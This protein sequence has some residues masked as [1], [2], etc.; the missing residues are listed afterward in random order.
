M[1]VL[2]ELR[3]GVEGVWESVSEGWRHLRGSAASALTRFK[4]GGKSSVPARVEDDASLPSPGWALLAGDIF[5]DSKKV[6]IRLEVPGME[7]E[8]FDIEVREDVVI[9]RG[10]KRLEQQVSEG[11]YRVMQCAYGTF[12]RTIP[13][14]GPVIAD[15]AKATY[16]NG[17]LKITLPKAKSARAR[18][19]DIRVG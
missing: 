11:R 9:V 8:D 10:E 5:E 19:I 4:P 1:K 12:Y 17:V 15:K 14:P 13:L 16:R 3:Q 2:E 18:T 6:L 7:K